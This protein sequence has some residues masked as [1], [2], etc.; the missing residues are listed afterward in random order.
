MPRICA[1]A[2]CWTLACG[3]SVCCKGR[4]RKG[5][6]QAMGTGSVLTRASFEG[7]TDQRL[8]T[9]GLVL[10]GGTV[11]KTR[12]MGLVIRPE[13]QHWMLSKA[14]ANAINQRF[15]FFDGST[16]RGVA[17]P[18]EDDYIEL[19]MH[20]RYETVLG[21]YIAVVR[22]VAVAPKSTSQHDRLKE[23]GDRLN[24]PATAADA[25]LQLE[26]TG[27]S[28]VPTLSAALQNDNPELRF[29]AAEALAY[30]DRPDAIAAL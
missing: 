14:I 6:L 5:D 19:E 15:F 25:A 24:D 1:A 28:A 29:Y 4:V 16:R 17:K 20:P 22:A 18:I 27:E 13:F 3:N 10:A 8:Q 9:Q 12:K 23:L 26:A 30:L 2:G 11:Q 7:N 21:R